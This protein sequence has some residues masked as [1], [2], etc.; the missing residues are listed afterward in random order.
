MRVFVQR[1]TQGKCVVDNETT[2]QI[3]EGFV[4]LVGFTHDD[5]IDEVK[6][7][8]KKVANLRVFDDNEGKMNLS[9]KQIN[10]SIL[11]ISQ[12]TLYADTKK[13]NRPSF[14]DAL[15]PKQAE[16][17]YKAFNEELRNTFDLTVETGIFGAE[18]EITLVNDGPVSILIESK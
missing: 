11:S 3:K 1:V 6:Y 7:C 8:A 9:V 12:F 2:G 13:G 4:A 16:D 5:G 14:T 15:H 18:M 17:L 10:G